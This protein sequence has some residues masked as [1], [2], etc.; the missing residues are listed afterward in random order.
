MKQTVVNIESQIKNAEKCQEEGNLS[1][2]AS[3]YQDLLEQQ[4]N[5]SFLYNKLGQVQAQAQ[6]WHKAIASYQKSLEL[7]IENPFWTYKNLGDALRE[8]QQFEQAIAF[9]Q[10]AIEIDQ[11]QPNVYDS[12]GQVYSLQGNY[13]DAIVAYQR[14]IDLGI[15]NQYWTCKNLGDALTA[16]NRLEEA[17]AA[18]QQGQESKSGNSSNSIEITTDPQLNTFQDSEWLTIHN[19]GDKYFKQEKWEEA[20][21][22]YKQAIELNPDYVW[23]YCNIS[24]ALAKLQLF[25]EL[26]QYCVL[27]IEMNSN[28]PEIYGYI[29]DIFA[30]QKQWEQAVHY[31]QQAISIDQS[32]VPLSV[33][34]NYNQVLEAKKHQKLGL[35]AR[36]KK[37]KSKLDDI[38][39]LIAKEPGNSSLYT[40]MADDLVELGEVNK[41]IIFYKLAMQINPQNTAILNSLNAI[42]PVEQNLS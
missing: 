40:A 19:Q 26:Q 23:S 11:S 38:H 21:A 2:A 42:L 32:S 27:A 13:P 8:I 3:I 4:P 28:H 5:N 9:Y 17:T 12:L 24:R 10:R 39:S 34:Q 22:S 15:S 14:A 30:E 6:D 41:A 1:L 31:Y 18:Y 33:F 35:L 20:I 29:G 37:P 36:K 25:D 16:E 7:D